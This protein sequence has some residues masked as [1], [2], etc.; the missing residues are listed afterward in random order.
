M[1]A[2]DPKTPGKIDPKSG[3]GAADPAQKQPRQ[4]KNTPK[5][6]SP[7]KPI[8]PKYKF[9]KRAFGRP[10]KYKPVY[11]K[12][13]VEYFTRPH[14][15][16]YTETHTNRKGETWQATKIRAVPVPTLQGFAASIYIPVKTL[17]QW[18]SKFEDFGKAYSHAQALQLD[19]LATVS[20]LGLYNS[21]W[22]VF[23]AKNVSDWR[24]RREIDHSGDL[25][26]DLF[27][28]GM[29]DKAAAAARDRAAIM[30]RN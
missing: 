20:G 26:I 8:D 2:A 27:V 15:E 9:N 13:I 6:S 14:T 24:D 22:A 30:G 5:S 10:S 21:N 16:E 7:L 12:K 23:M 18:A 3:T 19:H 28:A 29:V 17:W 11:C 1:A 4:Y 25:G